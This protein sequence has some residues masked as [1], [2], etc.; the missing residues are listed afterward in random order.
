M[1]NG[2]VRREKVPT[3]QARAKI[4]SSGLPVIMTTFAD[5]LIARIALKVAAPSRPGILKSRNVRFTDIVCRSSRA[6]LP[7]SAHTVSVNLT[8]LDLRMP[9]L[10]GAATFKAIRAMSVLSNLQ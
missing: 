4:S 8:F 3:F 1:V 7:H 10:D 2:L 6:L 5:G 9:G